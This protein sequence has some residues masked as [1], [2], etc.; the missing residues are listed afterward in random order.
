MVVSK[1]WFKWNF[2]RTFFQETQR[3]IKCELESEI[4][5]EWLQLKQ[6]SLQEALIFFT[7]ICCR[8]SGTCQ[9][10]SLTFLYAIQDRWASLADHALESKICPL[11]S[12]Q[13]QVRQE[14]K[15]DVRNDY[16]SK[17]GELGLKTQMMESRHSPCRM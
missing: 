13:Y 9:G 1:K 15:I 16:I 12:L 4:G 14:L 10:E 11:L 17:N 8:N 7:N 2:D 5:K 6:N 3:L